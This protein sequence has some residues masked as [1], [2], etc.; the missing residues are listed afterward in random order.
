MRQIHLI[1]AF[2][3][4]IFLVVITNGPMLS[5]VLLPKVTRYLPILGVLGCYFMIELNNKKTN[6]SVFLFAGLSVCLLAIWAILGSYIFSNAFLLLF[7]VFIIVALRTIELSDS[8]SIFIFKIWDTFV[9]VALFSTCF[10]FLVFNFLGRI[11]YPAITLGNYSEFNTFFNPLLGVISERD[12]LIFKLGRPVWYMTEPSYLG[13]FHG[14]NIFW[15]LFRKENF[16]KFY[17]KYFTLSVVAF[18]LTFSLGAWLSMLVSI[19]LVSLCFFV[20]FLFNIIKLKTNIFK[21]ILLILGI[22]GIV[23]LFFGSPILASLNDFIDNYDKYTSLE[24]RSDRIEVS[25]NLIKN[26]DLIRFFIGYGPG[27]IETISEAGESNGWLKY[28]IELGIFPIFAYIAML[29]YFF[30]RIRFLYLL[31]LFF[32]AVSFNSVVVMF[33]PLVLLYLYLLGAV[34]HNQQMVNDEFLINRGVTS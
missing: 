17:K 5:D 21:I 7:S 32:V 19:T 2:I 23:T 9:K 33:S 27:T 16:S 8:D 6:T 18:L 22:F 20:L 24:D 28:F 11:G 29:F 4:L 14:L 1:R 30:F 31:L 3:I 25:L 12:L 13:F 10:S 34:Q 26:M 15:V